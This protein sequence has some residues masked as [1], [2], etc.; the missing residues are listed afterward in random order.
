MRSRSSQSGSSTALRGHGLVVVGAVQPGAAVV[1]AAHAL[2]HVVEVALGCVLAPLEHQVLQ[3]VGEPGAAGR[4]VA[5]AGVEH[6]VHGHQRRAVVF[7]GH[8]AHPVGQHV[9]AARGR[10]GRWMRWWCSTCR[11]PG[12]GAVGGGNVTRACVAPCS[13]TAR[14]EARGSAQ[15]APAAPAPPAAAPALHS[16]RAPH[17]HATCRTNR[18][19]TDPPRPDAG[20]AALSLLRRLPQGALS[21]RLRADGGRAHPPRP[22]PRRARR[23]RPRGGRG[24]VRGGAA[25][26]GVSHP[27]PL[28]HAQAEGGCAVV[29]GGPGASSRRRWTAPWGSGGPSARGG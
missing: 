5:R 21:P 4:L 16:D 22:A 27:E 28:L 2:Q 13:P 23:V 15:P 10:G 24:P 8:H 1:G 26:G 19:P 6:Q 14:G 18:S 3:Q 17:R 7:V 25:A 9:R 11:E 12:S 29:A 20:G